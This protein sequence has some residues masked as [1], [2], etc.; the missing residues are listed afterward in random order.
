[1]EHVG[2]PRHRRYRRGDGGFDQTFTASDVS[3]SLFTYTAT[4][5]LF[6][7]TSTLDQGSMSNVEFNVTP[8]PEPSTLI[9]A[10]LG[11]LGI[12]LFHWRRRTNK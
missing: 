11:F 8:V 3:T 10:V 7:G 9:L 6:G 12:G 2:H 4:G 1:M 5:W